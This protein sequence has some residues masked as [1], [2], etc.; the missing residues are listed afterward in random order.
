MHRTVLFLGALTLFACKQ[1]SKAPDKAPA[2]PP[3][4]AAS[5]PA[6]AE[7]KGTSPDSREQQDDDG[8]V[9]R[10]AALTDG[11]AMTVAACLDKADELNGKNVKV[12]GTVGRVC[13]KKGCWFTVEEG[14]KTIRITAKD[15]G[16]FV[17]AGSPGMVA[18]LQGSLEVKTLD[19]KDAEHLKSEGAA[20]GEDRKEVSIVAAGLEMKKL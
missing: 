18:T 15:Y 4:A 9:R 19:E 11:D 10:G 6:S 16:F 3:K 1:Q 14:E 5:Q 7:A 20:I 12:T 13:T 8:I 2:A 17:P